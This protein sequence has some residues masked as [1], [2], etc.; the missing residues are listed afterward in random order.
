MGFSLI[1][2]MGLLKGSKSKVFYHSRK[3]WLTEPSSSSQT[4]VEENHQP[5]QKGSGNA[6]PQAYNQIRIFV[7]PSFLV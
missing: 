5:N 2:K 7:S 6:L 1:I 3:I 4:L